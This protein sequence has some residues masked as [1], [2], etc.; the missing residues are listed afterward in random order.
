M[1]PNFGF[2]KNIRIFLK[3]HQMDPKFPGSGDFWKSK[4]LVWLRPVLACAESDFAQCKR[5]FDF[6]S[7][8]FLTPHS[9]SLSGVWLCAVLACGES[10]SVQANTAESQW[11]CLCLR[12]TNFKQN[13]FSLFSRGPDGFHPEIKNDKK[14][15][16]IAPLMDKANIPLYICWMFNLF[17][18]WFHI[19][20]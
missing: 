12:E 19:E 9:V 17:N 1:L 15:C 5:I 7:F 11:F 6:Q 2:S 14:S 4:K 20:F 18:L 3:Y 16:D 13:H 10:D 8:Q